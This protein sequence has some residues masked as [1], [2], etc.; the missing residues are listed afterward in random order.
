VLAALRPGER[1]V[2]SPP[3]RLAAGAKVVVK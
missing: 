3:A 2:V 1:V